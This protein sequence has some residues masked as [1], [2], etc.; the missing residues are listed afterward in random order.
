VTCQD[1]TKEG[2][3]CPANARKRPDPDGQRR[4]PQHTL[5][6][7][8]REAI[9]LSRVRAG[10]VSTGQRP[11]DVTFERFETAESLD[12][13]FDEGLSVLRADLRLRKADKPR[14]TSA[15]AQLADA[16][17]RLKSLEYTARALARL[18]PGALTEAAS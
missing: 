4:C 18:K 7:A 13:L 10:L 9:Q 14:V 16:K 8:V 17:I 11:A 2:L 3:P 5:E 6:P 15:I 12:E 1:T